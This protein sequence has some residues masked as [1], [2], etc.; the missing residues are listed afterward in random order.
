MRRVGRAILFGIIWF[1]VL[2]GVS[3]FVTGMIVGIEAAAKEDDPEQQQ[4]AA[5]EAGRKFGE[6]YGAY[7]F[8]GAALI[9][10]VGSAAGILPGTK[11][12]KR[13]VA[14][15]AYYQYPPQPP[16]AQPPY[17]YPPQPPG[18]QPPQYPQQFPQQQPPYPQPPQ[19]PEQPPG[20][21]PPPQQT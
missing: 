15:A 8:L 19:Q 16:G 14:P 13:P 21:Q 7:F 18:V 2:L 4:A 20:S 12:K 9:A 5:E 3:F 11:P 6:R 1:V 10:V 17:Q